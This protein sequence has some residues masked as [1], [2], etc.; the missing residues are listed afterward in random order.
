[1]L[2]NGDLWFYIYVGVKYMF[3]GYDYLLFLVG[4]IFYFSSFKDILKFIIVFMV[5]YSII[6]L[7][8]IYAGVMVDEY[9]V[10][11]VIVLS[12]LYKGFENLGGF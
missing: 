4:V 3:I 10:D 1:M 5:G 2:S 9:L 6:L 8:V 12:V 7:S 11:V